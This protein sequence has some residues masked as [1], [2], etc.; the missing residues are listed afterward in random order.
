MCRRKLFLASYLY[1]SGLLEEVVVLRTFLVQLALITQ[2]LALN[3]Y[4][5]HCYWARI[6]SFLVLE[7]QV[8]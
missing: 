1:L 8:F 6:H 7:L 4:N 2:L 5:P 3:C